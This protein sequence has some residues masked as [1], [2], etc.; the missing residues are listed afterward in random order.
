MSAQNAIKH[1]V[2]SIET[3]PFVM[4]TFCNIKKGAS[5]DKLVPF[6]SVQVDDA[7]V[8]A[9]QLRVLL[10]N[11]G[12]MD[13]D[14]KFLTKDDFPLNKSSEDG[15]NWKDLIVQNVAMFIYNSPPI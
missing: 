11:A 14:D 7:I 13:N 9:A 5:A 10:K 2:D 4:V 8:T 1:F 12:T 15:V 6:D 3:R